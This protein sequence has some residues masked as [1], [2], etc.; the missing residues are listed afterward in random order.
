MRLTDDEEMETLLKEDPN[1]VKH[2]I[3]EGKPVL[4]AST[5]E[6]QAFVLKYADDER[7]FSEETVLSR[8]KPEEPADPNRIE[9]KAVEP[10]D[11]PKDK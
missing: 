5:K 2:E 8:K 4:T 1:A 7:L 3:V 11:V 6:L 10:N 9:Q